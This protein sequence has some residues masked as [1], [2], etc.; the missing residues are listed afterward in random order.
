M[1]ID[2]GKILPYAIGGP[3]GGFLYNQFFND[4]LKRELERVARQGT[5]SPAERNLFYRQLRDQAISSAGVA[6]R[7]GQAI[8]GQRGLGDTGLTSALAR[9]IASGVSAQTSGAMSDLE[10]YNIGTRLQ[11]LDL[12]NQYQQYI[13]QMLAQM[14]A[15]LGQAVGRGA[16]S[17]GGAAGAV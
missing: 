14:V 8:T 13:T 9:D 3:L 4:P 17:A 5:L 15:G 2:W 11:G 16:G 10:K 1:A 12:W 7:M 6:T